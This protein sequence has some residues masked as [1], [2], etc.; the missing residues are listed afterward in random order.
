[1]RIINKL[2][3]SCFF[4]YAGSGRRGV[5]L[6]AGQASPELP[7]GRATHVQLKSDLANNRIELSLSPKDRV[8]LRG[9][10]PDALVDSARDDAAVAVAV[11]PPPPKA[12][13]P[14]PPK[15]APEPFKVVEKVDPQKK[16]NILLEETISSLDLLKEDARQTQLGHLSK[17][18]RKEIMDIWPRL[19]E[20]YKYAPPAPA[21]VAEAPPVPEPVAAPAAPPAPAAGDL[22]KTKLAQ[23]NKTELLNECTRRGLPGDPGTANSKLRALIADDAKLA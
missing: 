4:P 5:E 12:A 2:P 6:K 14:P 21:P 1:M 22:N 11:A 23:M 7:P 13:P 20:H 3:H 16:I 15:T 19:A 10:L 8:M 18:K 9:H 17:S